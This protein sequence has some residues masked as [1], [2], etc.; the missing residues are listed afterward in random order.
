MQPRMAPQLRRRQALL[1]NPRQHALQ[2]VYKRLYFTP[3]EHIVY[4]RGRDGVA[5]PYTYQRA[6]LAL[7]SHPRNAQLGGREGVRY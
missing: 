3:L 4:R 1:R 2:Y 6:Q 7:T 5:T